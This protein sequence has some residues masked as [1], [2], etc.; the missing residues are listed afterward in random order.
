MCKVLFYFRNSC[1]YAN[2]K[3]V[4]FALNYEMVRSI[5]GLP[6]EK[7]GI[8]VVNQDVQ[9]VWDYIDAHKEQYLDI[10]K[11]F[12][13]QPSVSAQ[14]WGMRE[15]AEIVRETISDLGG[16]GEL[17]ETS[18]NPVVC[19]ELNFGRKRTLTL[20][21]HYDVVPPEPYELWNTPPFEP[22]I[23]GDKMV[24][25]GVADNKG[26]LLSRYCAIDAYLH[27]HGTLPINVKFVAEG[28]EEIGS[29]HL[30]E[31]IEANRQRIQSDA[32]I[33][34]GSG[35]S[36]NH[37]PLHVAL[38]VKGVTTF[39]L[40][41]KT[42]KSEMHALYSAILPNP[43]WRLVWALNSMKNEKDEITI[44]NFYDSVAPVTDYERGFVERFPYDEDAM[45]AE[46]G[47]KDFI[48]N[49]TGMPLKEKL[50]LEP[51]FNLE[52]FNGGNTGDSSKTILPSEAVV[53]V[54]I[55]TVPNQSPEEL[56]E[57]I[58]KHLDRRGF[59]DIEVVPGHSTIPFRGSPDSLLAKA[60]I[61]NVEDVYHMA[62]GVLLN[63]AGSC[64]MGHVCELTGIP[65]VCFGVYNEGSNCHAPNEFVYL[66]DY[67]NGI[68]LSA[69]VIHDFAEVE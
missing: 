26:S 62:P 60:V 54:D 27:V 3:T 2:R 17:V 43:I 40:R 35:K 46:I 44:D 65:A 51:S 69:A 47:R 20:Y 61:Q 12:C 9:K 42:V 1:A 24:A 45:R 13:S 64:G 59:T 15:M 14:N 10:L 53:K 33:W 7:G 57:L 31:F 23:V 22:T 52:G 28:E 29:V 30:D 6:A 48:N 56:L 67:F 68:K 32:I 21:N 36:L 39:E 41:C 58:R 49:L 37:G 8:D 63:M 25:R 16:N 11:K 38:G 66:D 18:G 34:E 5:I 4:Q 55:R 19:G 50:Y